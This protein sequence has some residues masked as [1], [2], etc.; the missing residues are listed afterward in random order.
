[1]GSSTWSTTLFGLP[2]KPDI[3]VGHLLTF[4]TLMAGFIWWLITTIRAWRRTSRQDAESGALR[5]LLYLLREKQGEPILL[6][7]LQASFNSPDLKTRRKVY[8][9]KNYL[10]RPEHRFERAIYQLDWEGKIDFVGTQAVAFRVDRQ[11]SEP[12]RRALSPTEQDR[13][14]ILRILR[15]GLEDAKG[16]AYTLRGTVLAAFSVAPQETA[17]EVRKQLIHADPTVQRRAAELMSD[18]LKKQW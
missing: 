16:E 3:D 4:V 2:I 10:L 15:H 12:V 6:S 9:K 5:L 11:P 18:M 17:D 8:C 7:D 1:M 14:E 13:T